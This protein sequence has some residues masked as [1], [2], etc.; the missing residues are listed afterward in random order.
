MN[1]PLLDLQAQY[2]EIEEE[3]L[4]SVTKVFKSKWFIMGPEVKELEKR[5]AQ[6]C[7]T[8]YGIA[9]ASGTDALLLALMAIGVKAGDEVITSPYTF[10][11]TAGSIYRLGAVPVFVDIDPRTYNIDPEKIEE[12]ITEKTKAIIPV[13]LYGQM[14][15]MEPIMDIARRYNLKVIEDAAQSIGAKY[16]KGGVEKKAGS[17]GDFGCFSFYPSKN[18]GAAGDGG[19]IVT[20]DGELAKMAEILRNHGSEPKYYHKIVGTNSR[21]DTIQA[22]VLLIKMKYLDRWSEERRKNAAYYDRAFE[23][24]DVVIPYIEDYNYSIYNQYIIRVK[25]RDEVFQYLKDKGVG[26]DIYYPVPLHLQ[27]CFKDLGYGKGDLKESE[28]AAEETLAIPIFSELTSDQMDY[29][30]EKVLR[31]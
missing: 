13:H 27:E 2:S 26:C 17:I 20:N 30:V 6:Y 25:D 19:M 22:A 5:I 3:I 4:A 23:G 8:K 21:L 11:A 31:R 1:V 12:K 18:L 10:F 29:V 14:C 16:C 24:T 15:H 9:V 28:K 7:G